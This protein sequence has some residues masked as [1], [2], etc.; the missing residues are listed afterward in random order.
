MC[1]IVCCGPCSKGSLS[2]PGYDEGD[3]RVCDLCRKRVQSL[4]GFL[5]NNQDLLINNNASNRGIKMKKSHNL[6]YL[7]LNSISNSK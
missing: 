1:G 6:L 3:E 2:L 5:K 4:R 7:L